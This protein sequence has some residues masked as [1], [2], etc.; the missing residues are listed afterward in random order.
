MATFLNI[1]L[2][3]TLLGVNMASAAVIGQVMVF[4]GSAAQIIDGKMEVIKVGAKIHDQSN[5]QA[6]SNAYIKIVMNDRNILVV[7]G[8]SDLFIN[9]YQN[10]KKAKK[11][12]IT[13]KEGSLRHALKQKYTNKEDSYQV[14]TATSVAGVRGTDFLTQYE[15]D[16][17]DTV[18]CTLEGKVSFDLLKNGVAENNPVIAKAGEFIRYK[19]DQK[20]PE[21]IAVK[22][23]WL[24]KALANHEL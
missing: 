12:L 24:E 4:K 23:A 18:L 22:K 1:G 13:L 21:V 2:L 9:E 15:L 7:S 14:K 20:I 16:S 11:V 3:V 17:G 8:K 19:K 5:I 10:T 6:E